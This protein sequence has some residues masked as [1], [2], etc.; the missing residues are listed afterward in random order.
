MSSGLIKIETVTIAAFNCDGDLLFGLRNLTSKWTLA[1]GHLKPGESPLDGA[2]R[3]LREETGLTP[4]SME[5]LGSEEVRV[6]LVVH[7]YQALVDGTPTGKNDP[8]Q[9][10]STWE[11]V[12]TQPNGLP[13][14]LLNNLQHPKNVALRL[15]GLLDPYVPAYNSNEIDAALKHIDPS[16][17]SMALKMEGV[18]PRHLIQAFNT[19]DPA[20]HGQALNHAAMT[21]EVIAHVMRLD[22]RHSLQERILDHKQ[23]SQAH[24]AR[25]ANHLRDNLENNPEDKTSEDLLCKLFNEW[26][27][28]IVMVNE[29]ALNNHLPLKVR[30]LLFSHPDVMPD[31]IYQALTI[32]TYD[33]ALREAALKNPKAPANLVLN[34]LKDPQ[35][36]NAMCMAAATSPR[37]SPEDLD[38]VLFHSDFRGYHPKLKQFAL[39]N[40]HI[41]AR[42]V[43]H[44]RDSLPVVEENKEFD[45][46]L[47]KFLY[48]NCNDE[49]VENMLGIDSKLNKLILA[50]KFLAGPVTPTDIRAALFQHDGD[51]PAAVLVAYGLAPTEENKKALEAIQELQDLGKSIDSGFF[52][53]EVKAMVPNAEDTALKL[54]TAFKDA[55]KYEPIKLNGKHISGAILVH[56][57]DGDWLL[58]PG[59]GKQS[60][61]MG[62]SDDPATQS[63]REAAFWHV[64][65]AFGLSKYMPRA[66]W[67]W[68]VDKDYA[69]IKMLDSDFVNLDTRRKEANGSVEQILFPYVNSGTIWLWALIDFVLGNSDRHANNMLV[70]S[71]NEIQLI[72]HGS[73]F[74]GMN[75]APGTDENSFVPY[76][77]RYN[78][79]KG[80]NALSQE[81]RLKIIPRASKAI[82]AEL[83]AWVLTLDMNDLQDALNRYEIDPLPCMARLATIQHLSQI[84]TVDE[85]LA[86]LWTGLIVPAFE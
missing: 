41:Q 81:D 14:G 51:M 78:C 15:L 1:G 3:E 75:F 24:I 76:Y 13:E 26:N 9:E 19:E 2:N 17:R 73:A 48:K 53:K 66:D 49:V 38:T 25:L 4:I 12:S 68:I 79:Q 64:A 45:Q 82:S 22:N 6:G 84:M 18:Q 7:A 23:T 72:D 67:L 54:H 52:E 36:S 74:A 37:L 63:Q 16:E 10:C 5:F 34:I 32:K 71:K 33:P 83:A 85:A 69:A 62:L 35:E 27:L 28:D 8:D 31:L 56:C 80:F 11:W 86:Q 42:H 40:P 65:E 20:I 44:I 29:F 55:S 39:L 47:N 59:S 46:K 60:P 70:N 21:P 61:A 43:D 57:E 50:V 77:L 58:K 30:C